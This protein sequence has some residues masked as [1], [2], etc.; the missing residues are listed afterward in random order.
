MI[1]EAR[2]TVRRKKNQQISKL[3]L[4][5][6][7]APHMLMLRGDENIS[8]DYMNYLEGCTMMLVSVEPV[9]MKIFFF[10][11]NNRNFFL[12]IFFFSAKTLQKHWFSRKKSSSEHFCL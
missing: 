3:I 1:T 11:K 7:V 12:L 5:S 2:F 8:I 6:I 10:R 9:E 4:E